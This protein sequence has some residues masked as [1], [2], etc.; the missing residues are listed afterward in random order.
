MN[1]SRE[2]A[3]NLSS[4]IARLSSETNLTGEIVLFA[5]YVWLGEVSEIAASKGIIVGA[6]DS[7]PQPN[8]AYTGAVNTQMLSEV[9]SMV[10]VG[11]SERRTVFGLSLIHI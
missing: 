4:A 1:T 11:H 7:Y 3:K 9:C 8:G 10:L 2:E 5:P 6:Q